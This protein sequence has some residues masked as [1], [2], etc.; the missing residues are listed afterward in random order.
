MFAPV[1]LS[2]A[3]SL[4]L[5]GDGWHDVAAGTLTFIQQPLFADENGAPIA[6]PESWVFFVDATTGAVCAAPWKCVGPVVL[7]GLPTGGPAVTGL[8]PSSGP[9][10]G[11]TTVTITGTGLAGATGAAFGGVAAPSFTADSATQVTAVSPPGTGAAGVTVTTP[12][13]TSPE[14]AAGQFTYTP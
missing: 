8:A 1:P 7:T 9:G 3:K 5:I 11:G 14:T 6:S 2:L 13:G 4:F 12:A 10:A